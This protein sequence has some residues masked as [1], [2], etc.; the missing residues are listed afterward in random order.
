[1]KKLTKFLRKIVFW[2]EKVEKKKDKICKTILIVFLQFFLL[3]FC[4]FLKKQFILQEEEFFGCIPMKNVIPTVTVF[5]RSK[6]FLWEFH[7]QKT[8]ISSAV[9]FEI[10]M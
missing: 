5:F 8:L 3:F 1:M 10:F 6:H 7:P 2:L 9:N 4:N